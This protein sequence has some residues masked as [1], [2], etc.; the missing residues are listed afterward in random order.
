MDRIMRYAFDFS[1][2]I[3]RSPVTSATKSNGLFHSM[4]FWAERFAAVEAALLDP[5]ADLM[6]DLGE[7]G[8]RDSLTQQILDC[9]VRP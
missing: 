8:T 6:P 3:G 4:P 5:A 2:Q 1:R 9:L 7:A